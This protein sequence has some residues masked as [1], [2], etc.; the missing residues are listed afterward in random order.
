MYL[1]QF[2]PKKPETDTFT[3]EVAHETLAVLKWFDPSSH[4]ELHESEPSVK[5]FYRDKYV[6]RIIE[7]C[8]ALSVII[9]F[10]AFVIAFTGKFKTTVIFILIGSVIIH[11]LNVLRIAF[12]NIAFYHFPEYE[13]VLH[14]VI[15]PL[16]IYSVV[17]LLW[18]IWVNKYSL[19]AKK[20]VEK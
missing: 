4:A 7:G 14:G 18:V 6:S 10:I 9:L 19:Y 8:N 2:D 3:I 13:H 1:N 11:I 20:S 17:F 16:I 15:F 5:M 12:L